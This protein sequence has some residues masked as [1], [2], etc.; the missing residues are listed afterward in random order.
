M[1]KFLDSSI[2][3]D[4]QD[5]PE[6]AAQGWTHTLTTTLTESKHINHLL[7]AKK[8]KAEAIIYQE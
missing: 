2:A 3:E 5:I 7:L 4:G 1:V 6:M 8:Q